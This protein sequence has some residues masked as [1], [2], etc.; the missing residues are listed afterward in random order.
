M[1]YRWSGISPIIFGTVVTELAYILFLNMAK[2]T[3]A[4]QYFTTRMLIDV[5]TRLMKPRPW[6]RGATA[7]S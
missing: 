5:M 6:E 2:E 4:E 7:K 1:G 3:G